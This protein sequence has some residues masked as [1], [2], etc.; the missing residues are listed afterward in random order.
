MEEFKRKLKATYPYAY[1]LL[2]EYMWE[3]IYYNV[4]KIK[5]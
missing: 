1:S 3:W 5:Q 2:P 4:K